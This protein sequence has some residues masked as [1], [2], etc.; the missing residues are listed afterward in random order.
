MDDLELLRNYAIRGL[1]TAFAE[2]VKRHV[3]LVYATALR[4]VTNAHLAEE[5]TQAV[6]LILSRKARTLSRETVVAGWLYRT[7]L[8]V[9]ADAMRAEYRRHHREAQAM[10]TM[11]SSESESHWADIAPQLDEAM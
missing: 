1:E 11:G 6:F 2:L 4:R 8:H 5:V 3:D 10:Q 9:A 7:A